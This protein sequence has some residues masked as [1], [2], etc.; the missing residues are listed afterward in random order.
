MIDK[1]HDLHKDG[2]VTY[3]SIGAV[4]LIKLMAGVVRVD[5]VVWVNQTSEPAEKCR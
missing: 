4:S 3:I 1:S 2:R 5:K